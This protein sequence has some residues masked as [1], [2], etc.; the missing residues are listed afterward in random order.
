MG[1]PRTTRGQPTVLG[2]DPKG[3]NF[4]YTCGQSVFIRDIANPQICDVYSQHPAQTTVAK[5]S[6]SGFY[7]ASAD[8]QGNVRIWDTV[9]A[10]HILKFECKPISGVISDLCWSGDSQR[11]AV[12]GE[13]REKFAAVFDYAAG[14]TVGEIVGHTKGCSSI[15]FKQQRPFRI[16]TGSIDQTVIQYDGPPYKYAR[17]HVDHERFVNCVR[18]SPDGERYISVGSDG[19]GFIYDG[20]TGDKKAQLD[21]ADGHKSGIWTVCW[22][23]DNKKVMTGSADKTV[24]IWD[25]ETLKCIQTFNVDANA[26]NDHQI[27]GSLWQ[28]QYMLATGLNGYIYYLDSNNPDKPMRVLKGHNKFITA[29]AYDQ[30]DKNFYTG[31]Y[32]GIIHRWVEGES[33]TSGV[34]GAT[35]TNEVVGLSVDAANKKVYSAGKDDSMRS[36]NTETKAQTGA[37]VA[38]TGLPFGVGCHSSGIQ[39]VA[40]SK[41]V[42][43]MRGDKVVAMKNTTYDPTCVAVSVDGTTAAVGAADNKI[44]IWTIDGDTLK[45]TG[46]LAQHRGALTTLSYSPD[47]TLLASGDSNREV[48]VW[49]VKT[50]A[51]KCSGWVFHTAK[52]KS[53]AWSPDSKFVASA[54]LD[55]QIIVWSVEK[56]TSRIVNKIAHHMGTNGVVFVDQNTLASVGQDCCLKTWK[57]TY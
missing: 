38:T 1:V 24:K 11:V 42:S 36:I 3:K 14:N 29:L 53:V 57:I 34:T 20:K 9:N 45:E 4:L 49:D 25:V 16:V 28:G 32:D 56:P 47:G 21:A 33:H 27:L 18:F 48:L 39:V 44:H 54:G 50:K 2:G 22:S 8:E 23:P 6:P 37:S 52:V 30:T 43:L 19:K 31:S 15:D 26:T 35:H 5:Y 51:V 40:T 55:Q 13:G 17:T 7:I 12:C 41:G 46:E 10:E